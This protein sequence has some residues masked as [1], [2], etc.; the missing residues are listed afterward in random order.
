[1]SLSRQIH[2]NMAGLKFR[3]HAWRTYW[4][5]GGG[6]SRRGPDPSKAYGERMTWICFPCS[7]RRGREIL[8]DIQTNARRKRFL[9]TK[10]GGSAECSD[11]STAVMAIQENV[12]HAF[13]PPSMPEGGPRRTRRLRH[14][15]SSEHGTP[16]SLYV[17]K[18]GLREILPPDALQNMESSRRQVG[19]GGRLYVALLP[20]ANSLRLSNERPSCVGFPA[21]VDLLVMNF[22]FNVNKFLRP[23][24]KKFGR[25][26]IL[27]LSIEK[28]I[29]YNCSGTGRNEAIY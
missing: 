6:D 8:P 16:V 25:R 15:L 2:G 27:P 14:G 23:L 19:E 18:H 24:P 10:R 1:M 29:T 21:F 22:V 28:P 11:H 17:R 20:F 13:G 12:W 4:Q 5:C 9:G 26:G 7:C 3:Q